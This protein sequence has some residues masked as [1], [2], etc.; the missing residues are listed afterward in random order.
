MHSYITREN[1]DDWHSNTAAINKSVQPP[2]D[3]VKNRLETVEINF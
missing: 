3:Y 1:S 2:Y